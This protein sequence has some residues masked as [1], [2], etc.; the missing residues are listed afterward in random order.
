M[1]CYFFLLGFGSLI[2]QIVLLREL[3]SWLGGDELFYALGLGFWLLFAGLGNFLTRKV[4]VK[5]KFLWPLFILWLLALPLELVLFRGVLNSWLLF[6]RA[7]SFLQ[8]ILIAFGAVALSSFIAG[9]LFNLAVGYWSRTRLKKEPASLAN[10][11]YFFET[12]GFVLA[13]FVYTFLLSQTSFPLWQKLDQKTLSPRYQ[14]LSQVVYSKQGQLIVS[15]NQGQR[16]IFFSG[17]PVFN[18]EEKFVSRKLSGVIASV[19][20]DGDQLLGFGDLNLF[21]RLSQDFLGQKSVFVFP[22]KE[23]YQ[24]EKDW[25]TEQTE[26]VVNDPRFYLTNKEESWNLIVIAVGNPG[27]LLTNRYYTLEFFELVKKRLKDNGSIILVF[28]LPVDYQSKEAVNFGAVIYQTI[29]KVFAKV[30]ILVA[31]ERVMVLASLTDIDLEKLK[32]DPYGLTIFEDS[33]RL[34]I[35]QNFD[36]ARV[37]INQDHLPLAYF[38]HHLFW[39]TIF[40]FDLPK[41]SAKLVWLLPWALLLLPLLSLNKGKGKLSRYLATVVFLSNFILMAMEVLI[42]FLFQTKIGNLYSQLSLVIALILLGMSVGVWFEKRINKKRQVLDLTFLSYLLFFFVL[43]VTNNWQGSIVFWLLISLSVGLIDG[44][45]YSLAN[46]LWFEKIETSNF[47]YSCEL[48]GS[49][50]GAM[51]TATY[52]LPGLGVISLLALFSLLVVVTVFIARCQEFD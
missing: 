38:R 25:L 8:S 10:K 29:K 44:L 31:E 27:D 16:T 11:A 26:P 51:V 32:K 12:L 19:I 35:K 37:S 33:R 20:E 9:V 21:N 47:I 13:G 45:I 18:S 1:F 52:L 15:E 40:S 14:N 36:S 43:L 42:I 2:K 30:E 4:V 46:S 22:I 49:F 28:D 41:I 34:L 6:G 50:F 7:P 17:Q 3:V 48:F 23:L 39:Q 5:K 24:L